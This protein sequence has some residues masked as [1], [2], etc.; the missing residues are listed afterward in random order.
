MRNG[1]QNQQ[2]SKEM[3]HRRYLSPVGKSSGPFIMSAKFIIS[4]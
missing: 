2:K 1:E 4:V 3:D